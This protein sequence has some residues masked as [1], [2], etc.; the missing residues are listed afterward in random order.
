MTS[1]GQEKMVCTLAATANDVIIGIDISKLHLDAYVHPKG[2]SVQFGNDKAGH[3]RLIVWARLHG[4]A[5]IIFEATGAYHRALELAL[6]KASIP[7]I[8][9]N[10]LQARRFAQ[11]TGKRVK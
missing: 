3:A 1:M 8:K 10:P 6:A 4:S 7:A 9:I 11:A 2:L 5:R